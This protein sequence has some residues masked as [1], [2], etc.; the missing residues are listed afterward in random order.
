MSSHLSLLAD[1]INLQF[2]V[3]LFNNR[4]PKFAQVPDSDAFCY[5]HALSQ[6]KLKSVF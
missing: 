6:S 3:T 1:P 2:T 4:L 5:T